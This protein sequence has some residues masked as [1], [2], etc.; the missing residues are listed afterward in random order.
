MNILNW[1][2]RKP[3]KP[4]NIIVTDPYVY[5]HALNS[6]LSDGTVMKAMTEFMEH[7]GAEF[8]PDGKFIRW[9]DEEA[10]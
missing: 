9:L 7:G 1:F 5:A 4:K 10:A 3:P 8:T 2:R 6:G